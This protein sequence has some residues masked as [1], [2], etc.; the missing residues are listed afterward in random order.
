MSDQEKLRRQLARL[1][2][3]G[4]SVG[5]AF[6]QQFFSQPELLATKTL[7]VYPWTFTDD[8]VMGIAVRQT[9]ELCGEI[10]Q[11]ELASRFGTSYDEDPYRGYGAIAHDILRAIH[12]GEPWAKV[13][14]TVFDG[15]GSMGNGAAMRA[16]PIGGYFYDDPEKAAHQAKLSAEVTHMHPEGIAGAIAVAVAAAYACNWRLTAPETK[17]LCLIR[18]TL[19]FVPDG[20]VRNGIE[21]AG[22]LSPDATVLEAAARLGCGKRILAQDTVPFCLWAADTRLT[23]FTEA[24]WSTASV[25]GDIDTN[26]AIVGSIVSLAVGKGGIPEEWILSR[27]PLNG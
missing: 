8:T 1:S 12:D 27:E 10:D 11:D 3:T 7:P 20:E 6:G 24:L 13:S 17:S 23:N 4:L 18:S 9:L 22:K 14:G 15:T 5:D 26:C 2:L 25:F 19:P 16:G 21:L